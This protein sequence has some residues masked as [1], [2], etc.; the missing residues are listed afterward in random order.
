M[1]KKNTKDTKSID[2]ATEELIE[3]LRSLDPSTEQYSAA[4]KNLEVLE[5]AK[6]HKKDMSISPDVALTV[7]G[8]LVGILAVLNFERLGVV[9][10]KAIGM[11]LKA[12]L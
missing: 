5:K 8:N 2:L 9:T 3:K 12:K 1:F 10:S 6:S 4:V 7:G 11:V